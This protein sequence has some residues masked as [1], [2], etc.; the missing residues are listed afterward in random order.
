MTEYI[1]STEWKREPEVAQARC[2]LA[3]FYRN[4]RKRSPKM[5]RLLSTRMKAAQ[6]EMVEHIADKVWFT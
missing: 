2:D 1:R 5:A 6:R 3:K 4:L